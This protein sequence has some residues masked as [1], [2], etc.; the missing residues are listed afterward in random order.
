[1]QATTK[2]K[3]YHSL[4]NLLFYV[5]LKVALSYKSYKKELNREKNNINP[6]P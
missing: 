5:V 2:H 6:I 4:I 3:Q 1:M